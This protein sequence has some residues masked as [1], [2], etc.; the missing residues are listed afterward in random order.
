MLAVDV[1]VAA[2]GG[3]EIQ[4]AAGPVDGPLGVIAGAA[5]EILR[6]IFAMQAVHVDVVVAVQRPDVA[7]AHVRALRALRVVFVGAG[8]DEVVAVSRHER[9]GDAAQARGG[10]LPGAGQQVEVKYLVAGMAVDGGLENQALAV[11]SPVGFGEIGRRQLR[12]VHGI[13]AGQLADVAQVRLLAGLKQV[14]A[15]LDRRFASGLRR[16]AGTAQQQQQRGRA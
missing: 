12:I 6:G 3:G 16:S 14:C 11:R 5:G 10:H 13:A 4:P 9:A 1:D 15:L 8:I 2:A 7:L